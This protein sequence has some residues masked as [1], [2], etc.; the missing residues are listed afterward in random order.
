MKIDDLK[1]KMAEFWNE[2]KRDKTGLFGLIL[3]ILFLGTMILEKFISPYPEANKQWREIAYWENNVK[4][5]RPIWVNLFLKNKLPATTTMKN[6]EVKERQRTNVKEFETSFE[7]DFKWGSAPSDLVLEFDSVGD[8]QIIPSV[9]RPDGQK[10]I[11]EKVTYSTKALKKNRIP[12]KTSLIEGAYKFASQVDYINTNT[13]QKISI[14]SL[15]VTFA[16]AKE[17]LA[18]KPVGLPGLYTIKVKIISPSANVKVDNFKLTAVGKVSGLMGTDNFKRDIFSGLIAGVK[19]AFIIGFLVA[20]STVVIGVVYGVVSAYYGGMI[21]AIMQR[22]VEFLMNIPFLPVLIVV[23]AILKPSIW[24]FIVLMVAL[25]WIGPVRVV[26]SMALQIK[27]ETFIE[28]SRA[29]GASNFRLIFKHMLPLVI[30]FAFA[31]MA[32]A[33]PSAILSEAGISILGLGD[34]TIVTW[35]QMLQDA[36]SGGALITGM[37][38]WIIPPGIMISLVGMSFSFVGFAMDKILNPKL[39]T[40]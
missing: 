17:N 29:L 25:N 14:D 9:I 28:A 40:R 16:D 7:Y 37:W 6:G 38:W 22:I 1:Y 13:V 35:G 20:L 27:E 4:S 36:K 3:I 21:D 39:K 18:S 10:I 26:R 2:F 30:P 11:G 15:G 12:L 34:S 32:L 19:W 8:I 5:A 23:S 24:T 31:N 33:V